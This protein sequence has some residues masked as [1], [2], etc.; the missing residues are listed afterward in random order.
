MRTATDYQHVVGRVG[1]YG[2]AGHAVTFLFSDREVVRFHQLMRY[3][4]I[5]PENLSPT[6]PVSDKPSN[7]RKELGATV[8]QSQPSEYSASNNN[9]VAD[10]TNEIDH[11][12]EPPFIVK[13][14][15]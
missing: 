4:N 10:N 7:K 2:N 13:S 6:D 8:L 3:L 5:K 12:K 15:L 9:K 1:R 14:V 11:E